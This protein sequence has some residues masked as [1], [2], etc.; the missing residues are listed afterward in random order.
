[1]R[2]EMETCINFII[3][4]LFTVNHLM[5]YMYMYVVISSFLFMV[6]CCN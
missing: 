6:D 4:I 5:V 1:M 2:K 3:F